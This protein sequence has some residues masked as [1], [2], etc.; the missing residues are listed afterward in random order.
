MSE[1]K[2]SV[3]VMKFGGSCLQDAKSFE[4]TTHNIN[5]Y[6]QNNKIIIVASAI[7]GITDKLINFYHRS[8]DEQPEC[9]SILEDLFITHQSVIKE[10][11]ND[12]KPEYKYAIDFLQN[13]MEELTQL[14]RVIG[15]IRPSVD[16]QD[17]IVSYGEKLSTF[18]V[19]QYLNSI[20]YKSEFVSSDE[21][22]RTDDNFGRALPIL[23][24]TELLVRDRVGPILESSDNI[25]VCVTGFYGSTKDKKITTLGRGGSDLTAAI[26]AYCFQPTYNC[27]VIYWKDVNGFLNAD[28]RIAHKTA[29][30][31]NISYLEA[32]EL[33]F[34]GS[35]VLHPVC[36]DV[37][38]KREIPSEIRPFEDPESNEFTIIT[39]EIV[40]DDKIIKAITSIQKISMVTI[41]SGTMVSLPGTVSKLFSLLGDNNVNI[42]FISQSSSENNITFGIDYEDAMKVSF[43]LR[44]SSLFGKQWFNIKIDHEI[45]LIAVIG[46]GMLHTPG[47]AGK[48]FSTLGE[49]NVNVMAI[50]QGSSELNITIIIERKDC[51]KAINVLY[52]A[53]VNNS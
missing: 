29:L 46:A 12:K 25:I 32:K 53:F 22:I 52:D 38:E 3:V 30:L 40:K 43:L 41:A 44:N 49:N 20:G 9:E 21:I 39:K 36:L 26:M 5:L 7:K 28:P 14:G 4:Q 42:I 45:S 33:A 19:T 11:I 27:K 18:I 2:H 48:I 31:K 35:K 16:I 6:K 23:D 17:I 10:I 1:K 15:L 47:V 8:C 37:N 24:E 13:N 34:F 50:A 51:T